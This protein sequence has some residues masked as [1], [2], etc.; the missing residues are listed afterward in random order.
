MSD[1]AELPVL[2]PE[3]NARLRALVQKRLSARRAEKAGAS[4]DPAPRYDEVFFQGVAWLNRCSS[5]DSFED[6]RAAR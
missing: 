2:T 1:S 3:K 4:L 5:D 6:V